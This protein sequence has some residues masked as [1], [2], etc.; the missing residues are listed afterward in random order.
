MEDKLVVGFLTR[1]NQFIQIS[2][3]AEN[4]Q[5]DGLEVIEHFDY[6][7]KKGVASVDKTL[8]LTKTGDQARIQAIHNISVESDFYNVFRSVIRMELNDYDNR[9]I[10]RQITEILDNGG[11]LY[12]TKLIKIDA[13]LRQ[14][15]KDAVSFQNFDQKTIDSFRNISICQAGESCGKKQY[16]LASETG[17][18]TIFPKLH[19]VSRVD[20]EKVYYGRMADELVRYRRIR[21]F[22]FQTKSYLNISYAEY[23]ID[24]KEMFILDS[25]LTKDYFKDLVP[26]NTNQYITNIQYDD[27]Q[28]EITRNY[29][30]T[31][32]LSEQFALIQTDET[33]GDLEDYISTC[34]KETAPRVIGNDKVGS[35][36]VFFPPTA[37]EIVF[38]NTIVCSYIPVIYILQ[39]VLKTPISIQNV[40]T[41]LWNGYSK[42]TELHREKILALLRAHGKRH[43]ID[44]VLTKKS[45]L[46]HVI[47]SDEYYLTDLDLWIICKTAELP[48]V[49]F[50]STKL[51]YLNG[52]TDW[53]RLH[54][55]RGN[56]NEKYYFIRSPAAVSVNQPPA[57]QLVS[58]PYSF[59]ELKNDMFIK[60]DR[61]DAEY[62]ENMMTVDTFLSKYHVI[63]RGNYV[64]P[65]PLL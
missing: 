29:D 38:E 6:P 58:Q 16:C 37:K 56:P 24:G 41:T 14:L 46:E 1:T 65:S 64:P 44:L 5:S 34:I 36:R 32:S 8:A 19:L 25:L 3:P 15:T 45:T 21:T 39:K 62:S 4:I 26:Y 18:K 22:M 17:C 7:I 60:A 53:L 27:A 55:G 50:S 43:L 63:S 57:Y 52:G 23:Q 35:W 59:S 47:F 28:P 48:V 2:P 11:I 12:K 61:G 30:N 31:V 33:S 20:N 49:L 42:L 10:K 54:K 40:K 13:L 9:A 51:K